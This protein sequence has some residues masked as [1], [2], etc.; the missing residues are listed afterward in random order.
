MWEALK[1]QRYKQS[2]YPQFNSLIYREQ[3]CLYVSKSSTEI[4]SSATGMTFFMLNIGDDSE[5]NAKGKIFRK[6]KEIKLKLYTLL[7]GKKGIQAD[8]YVES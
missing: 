7:G 2:T 6:K 3:N 1:I 4:A 8:R 5:E